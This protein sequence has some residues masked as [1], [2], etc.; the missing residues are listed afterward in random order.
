MNICGPAVMRWKVCVMICSGHQERGW[1]PGFPRFD[2]FIS[3][4]KI[5]KP[6]FRTQHD[7]YISILKIWKFWKSFTDRYIALVA[8]ARWILYYGCMKTCRRCLTERPDGQFRVG[9]VCRPCVKARKH[10]LYINNRPAVIAAA[11]RYR[12]EHKES[13]AIT[14][15]NRY[16]ADRD[17]ILAQKREYRQR[18]LAK[19]AAK[20]ACYYRRNPHKFDMNRRRRKMALLQ[21]TPV[22]WF[23]WDGMFE[24][25]AKVYRECAVMRD[26]AGPC[27]VDHIIPLRGKLVSGLHVPANLCILV[28]NDNRTKGSKYTPWQKQI[29][30]KKTGWA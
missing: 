13:I 3:K 16:I 5:P 17:R 27:E 4:P 20:D 12:D 28:K 11:K 7:S 24:S 10:E 8:F 2:I 22:H 26:I 30:K 25:I 23:G 29:V 19:C 14:K 9:H 6:D 15:K 18:N 1:G 21:R